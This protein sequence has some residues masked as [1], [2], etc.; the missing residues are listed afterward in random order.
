MNVLPQQ[1][2]VGLASLIQ[3]TAEESEIY[4]N[5]LN[6]EV[7]ESSIMKNADLAIGVLNDLK[8]LSIKVSKDDF[9]T[10]YSSL[11]QIR[12]LPIDVLKIHKSFIDDFSIDQY[13]ASLV[14][15]IIGLAHNL[16][17]EVVAEG[18]EI[19]DIDHGTE[20]LRDLL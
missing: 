5:H 9:G 4:P 1:F 3:S 8:R 18:I 20:V 6:I 13:A 2:E 17:L 12:H 10:G 7:T 14:T 19:G 16:D 11:R 15:A